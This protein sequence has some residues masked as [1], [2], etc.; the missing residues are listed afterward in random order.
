MSSLDGIS[1]CD[2]D[3]F[4]DGG[5]KGASISASNKKEC[6]SCDQKVDNCKDGAAD[7]TSGSCNSDIGAVIEGVSK[8]D[9]SHDDNDTGSSNNEGLLFIPND[10]LFVDP[11]PKED[12]PICMLPMPFAS[13]LCGVRKTYHPC[14]GKTVCEGCVFASSEAVIKGKL[15]NWCA[16]CRVPHPSN[17]K[18]KTEAFERRMKLNDATAFHGLGYEYWVGNRGLP[19]N[20]KKAFELWTKAAELGSVDGYYSLA[21]AYLAG[22]NANQLGGKAILQ[23]ELAAVGG[24]EVARHSLGLL[25]E[26]RG[27]MCRAMKHYMLAARSGYDESLKKV[28]EGYKAGHV[29]KEDYTK[30]LR[31]YQLSIDEMKSEGRTK[32]TKFFDEQVLS[33]RFDLVVKSIS[34]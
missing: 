24:H 10:K 26:C 32:A 14:C 21:K 30:S 31:A 29:T 3:K 27:N 28:G 7:N 15:K 11:P 1:T 6:T 19:K 4:G 25:D 34:G 18:E 5:G 13:G 12:C 16:C 23:F 22:D 2:N 9:V 8:V 17:F 33:G 20:K